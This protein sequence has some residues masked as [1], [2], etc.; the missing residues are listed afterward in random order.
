[1]GCTTGLP[2]KAHTENVIETVAG[3]TVPAYRAGLRPGD[4]I[5]QIDD[6]PMTNGEE[7]V[8]HHPRQRGKPAQRCR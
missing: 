1:M 2:Y 3:T 7:M 5:V 6:T 8:S 4:R